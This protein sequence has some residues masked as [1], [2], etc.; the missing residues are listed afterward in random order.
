MSRQ[1]DFPERSLDVFDRHSSKPWEKSRSSQMLVFL[2]CTCSRLNEAVTGR[3]GKSL[4][5]LSATGGLWPRR[6]DTE[7]NSAACFDET[8]AGEVEGRVALKGIR[9]PT[10]FPISS[11]RK[12]HKWAAINITRRFITPRKRTNVLYAG[13]SF[14][15]YINVFIKCNTQRRN[16]IF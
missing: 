13:I 5:A 8:P 11:L 14:F 10:S 1:R 16:E 15:L 7:I 9:A 12:A 6:W 4:R 3:R 2:I